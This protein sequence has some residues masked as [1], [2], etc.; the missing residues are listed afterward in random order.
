MA[1]ARLHIICGNCGNK[2]ML[3]YSIQKQLND[4]TEEEYDMVYISCKNCGTLHDLEDNAE[5]EKKQLK[6]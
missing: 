6:Y 3:K 5:K 2:D 1:H 4:E